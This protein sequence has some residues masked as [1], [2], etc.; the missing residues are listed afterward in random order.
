MVTLEGPNQVATPT[1]PADPP[2]VGELPST[3]AAVH[4]PVTVSAMLASEKP[5][6]PAS[7]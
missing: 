4:G 1:V 3:P 7:P 2:R 5:N 6:V